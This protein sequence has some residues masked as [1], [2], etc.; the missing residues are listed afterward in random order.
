MET[1]ITFLKIKKYAIIKGKEKVL[2]FTDNLIISLE[3]PNL[4]I[5]Y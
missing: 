1:L 3:R 4:Q 5:N 2:L